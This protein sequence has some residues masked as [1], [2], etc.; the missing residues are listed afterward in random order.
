MRSDVAASTFL[1]VG[2]FMTL[3]ILNAIFQ[4]TSRITWALARDDALVFSKHLQQI[5]PVLDV[6]VQAIL[7][8]WSILAVC[9]CIFL[10]SSIG[11]SNLP[12]HLQAK[13]DADCSIQ[14]SMPSSVLLLY[15]SNFPL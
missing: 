15:F 7:L 13:S 8:N 9:G 6:P 14:P 11:E 12:L 10:G 4:T 2:I 1:V 3:F 5:H